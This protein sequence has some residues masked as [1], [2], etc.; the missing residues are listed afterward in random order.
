MPQPLRAPVDRQSPLSLGAWTALAGAVAFGVVMASVVSNWMLRPEPADRAPAAAAAIPAPS[1]PARTT[2]ADDIARPVAIG[3]VVVKTE[4]PRRAGKRNARPSRFAHATG[5]ASAEI[6]M[7]T[8]AD[9][10][11]ALM[12]ELSLH[13]AGA[14]DEG[15]VRERAPSGPRAAQPARGSRELSTASVRTIVSAARG[16]FE[17]CY[18][19]ALRRN[20]RAIPQ[21]V[22]L[23][24]RIAPS[25]DVTQANARGASLRGLAPCLE[26]V[27]R[28][29]ELPPSRSGGDVPIP[30]AFEPAG[31]R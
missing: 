12:G 6:G 2:S 29:F 3:S 4:R 31:A 11:G 22:E 27:A 16:R 24:V 28:R 13:R 21:R 7:R 25:G 8:G 23:F 10:G 14:A 26:T 20:G 5:G 30:L 15:T 17:Q 1:V 19:T 9:P 18:V